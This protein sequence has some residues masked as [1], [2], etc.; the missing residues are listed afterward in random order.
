LLCELVGLEVVAVDG[1]EPGDYSAKPPS[2]DLPEHLLI[3]R[4]ASL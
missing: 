2:V 1:A 3:A 4:M